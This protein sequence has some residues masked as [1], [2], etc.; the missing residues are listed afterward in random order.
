MKCMSCPLKYMGQTCRS[1]NTRYKEHIRDIRSNNINSGY[2]NHILNTGHAYGSITDTMRA[3]R[4]ER[5][6]KHLNT[7]EKYHIHKI[8]KERLHMNDTYNETNN[9]ILEPLNTR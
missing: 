3:I 1:F 8:S 9:P 5:K 6:G 7:L 2:P 4:T